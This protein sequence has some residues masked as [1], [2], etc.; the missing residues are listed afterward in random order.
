MGPFMEN[1]HSLCILPKGE[2]TG[3]CNH[4]RMYVQYTNIRSI[5]PIRTVQ[6]LGIIA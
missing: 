6:Y 4:M 2:V 5:A 1:L 3:T